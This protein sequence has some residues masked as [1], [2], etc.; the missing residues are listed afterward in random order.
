[1]VRSF[2]VKLHFSVNL[3]F[4]PYFFTKFRRAFSRLHKY[5]VYVYVC[6]RMTDRPLQLQTIRAARTDEGSHTRF[7]RQALLPE[8][9]AHEQAVLP[10]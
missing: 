6:L 1:M 10:R 9:G 4:S 5:V 7:R 8:N 2:N 3:C